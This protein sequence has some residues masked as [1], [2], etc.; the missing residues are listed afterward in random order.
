MEEQAL[1]VSDYESST[2]ISKPT[3]RL[4]I[5]GSKKLLRNDYISRFREQPVRGNDHVHESLQG[6]QLIPVLRQMPSLY[7]IYALPLPQ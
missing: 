3:P 5:G 7:R 2:Y 1:V 4:I 6:L